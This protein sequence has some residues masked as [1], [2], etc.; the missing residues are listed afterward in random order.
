M[1]QRKTN[2][3]ARNFLPHQSPFLVD[4]IPGFWVEATDDDIFSRP[5]PQD[6]RCV[7]KAEGTL[8]A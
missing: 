2:G 4:Q 5:R 8:V 1:A 6:P 7:F 3:T